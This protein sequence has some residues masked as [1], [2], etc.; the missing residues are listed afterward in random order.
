MKLKIIWSVFSLVWTVG[1]ARRRKAS[2]CFEVKEKL[3]MKMLD[4]INLFG[5]NM[6][7]SLY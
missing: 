7:L 4:W 3:G 5:P 1:I 2:D 6:G